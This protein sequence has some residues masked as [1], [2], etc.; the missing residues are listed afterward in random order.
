MRQADINPGD[1]YAIHPGS[2]DRAA[3]PPWALTGRDHPP[4]EWAADIGGLAVFDEILLK[5][6]QAGVPHGNSGRRIGVWCT[7]AGGF[8]HAPGEGISLVP[9]RDLELVIAAVALRPAP[10]SVKPKGVIPGTERFVG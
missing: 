4:A 10:E 6:V 3:P 9:T 8:H 2:L 7:V 5:V 1:I